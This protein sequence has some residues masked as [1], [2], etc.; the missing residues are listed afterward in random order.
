MSTLFESLQAKLGNNDELTPLASQQKTIAESLRAKS[1]KAAA[2]SGP[3]AS[4]IGEQATQAAAQ[5]GMAQQRQAGQLAASGI[6]GQAEAQA[7]KIATAKSALASNERVAQQGLARQGQGAS[8]QLAGQEEMALGQSAFN[9]TQRVEMVNVTADQ[10]FRELASELGMS[11]DNIFREFER[12]NK[13]LAFRQD[14]ARIEQVG[15]MLAMRDKA[16]LDELN[17]IGIERDLTDKLNYKEDMQRLVW[18]QELSLMMDDLGFKTKLNANQREWNDT[19]ARIDL[20]TALKLARSTL[21]DEQQ[22][23]MI[24]G[25]GNLAKAGIDAYYKDWDTA[26]AAEQPSYEGDIATD[27]SVTATA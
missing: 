7:E 21:A 10:K 24:S 14:G 4:S 8:E 26:P 2:T 23:Q 13:E 11:T 18:G 25:T 12:S 3:A 20:S 22:S 15:F 9:E 17:R 19:L 6:A 1:G 5:T 27:D 16:Y